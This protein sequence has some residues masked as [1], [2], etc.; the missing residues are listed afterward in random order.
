MGELKG[1]ASEKK[2]YFNA[3]AVNLSYGE[4]KAKSPDIFFFFCKDTQKSNA[5]HCVAQLG[6][7]GE[8][9]KLER[10]KDGN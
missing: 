3:D 10:E 5:L 8:G 1:L 6:A 7:P 4:W 2:K 9:K